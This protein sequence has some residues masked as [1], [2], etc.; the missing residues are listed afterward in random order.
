MNPLDQHIEKIISLC[1]HHKVARLFAFGSVLKENVFK[2]GSDIDLLVDFANIELNDY[3][4]NYFELKQQLE[5]LFAR[6]VDLLEEKAL[7]NP[8]YE[9]RN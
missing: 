5:Q 7:R 9:R 4:D 2:E 6:P 8:Y 1:D 3:A